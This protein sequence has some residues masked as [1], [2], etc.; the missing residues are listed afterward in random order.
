[1]LEGTQSELGATHGEYSAV[2][3]G[4][5]DELFVAKTTIGERWMDAP[6]RCKHAGF[7]GTALV[8]ADHGHGDI[9]G[10]HTADDSH[11]VAQAELFGLVDTGYGD[12]H[13]LVEMSI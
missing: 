5:S 12:R 7:F 11:W 1:V 9:V 4:S 10:G 13:K 6:P 2:D 8:F 3:V